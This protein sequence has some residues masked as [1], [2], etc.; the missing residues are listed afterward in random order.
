MDDIF[1]TKSRSTCPFRRNTRPCAYFDLSATCP[2]A[3][4]CPFFLVSQSR[5]DPPITILHSYFCVRLCMIDVDTLAPRGFPQQLHA[6]YST[7]LTA[8]D[9]LL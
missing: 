6:N 2:P 9:T 4:D 7:V 3:L 8:T 5:A 1:S